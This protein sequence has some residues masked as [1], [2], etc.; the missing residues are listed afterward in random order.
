MAYTKEDVNALDDHFQ[1]ISTGQ[2]AIE[3]EIR[4]RK[5][6]FKEM[7]VDEYQH[8]RQ[9]MLRSIRLTAGPARARRGVFVSNKGL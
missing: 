2:K 7:S 4:G 8:L 1:R 3:Y 6:R 9:L 5:A